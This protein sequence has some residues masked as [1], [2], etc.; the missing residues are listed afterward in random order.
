MVAFGNPPYSGESTNKGD[1]IMGLMGSYKK[2][3]GGKIKLQEKNS[4]WLNDDYVKFIR[5]GEHY[6]EKNGEGVMAYITNHSYLDNPTFRGMR[7][8]LLNTFDDIYILDLHGNSLK[9]ET[10][11]DGSADVNVFDIQQGVS[12]IIAVKKKSKGR[13]KLATVHH[14]DLYGKRAKKYEILTDNT[15]QS[16]KWQVL[17]HQEPHFFFVPKDFNTLSE[18]QKGFALNELFPINSVGIITARDALTIHEQKENLIKTIHDFASIPAEE[19]R[20]K[21]NLG[22]DVRDWKVYLAQKELNDT[23]LNPQNT[24]KISYRP[25]DT[26]WTYFTGKSKGF[27]CMPRGEVIPSACLDNG[28]I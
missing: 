3:P 5:L 9:K 12:I 16:I 15:I 26:H 4:K 1:Y 28:T 21:Y 18:Y 13:K 27:H 25:F 22:K 24:Q 11:P 19:A 14:A 17:D 2:E 7:W 6:I 10:A 20:S 8:H 23:K